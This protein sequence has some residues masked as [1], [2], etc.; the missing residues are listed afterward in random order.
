MQILNNLNLDNSFMFKILIDLILDNK[1][2]RHLDGEFWIQK[3]L[4]E[5]KLNK[6]KI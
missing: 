4:L 1:K 6:K 5:K 3:I 2:T